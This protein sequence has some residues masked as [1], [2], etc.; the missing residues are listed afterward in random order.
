MIDVIHDLGCDDDGKP[1]T[2][3]AKML[4]LAAT[5]LQTQSIR[6]DFPMIVFVKDY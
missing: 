6:Q 4:I 5:L 1:L 2:D 3:P